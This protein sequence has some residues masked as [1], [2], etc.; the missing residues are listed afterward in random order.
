MNDGSLARA[1]SLLFCIVAHLTVILT[2]KLLSLP[3][4][5]RGQLKHEQ[6]EHWPTYLP[7]SG[8]EVT[9]LERC[10]MLMLLLKSL[11]MVHSLTFAIYFIL[12][13]QT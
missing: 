12:V 9:L 1:V 4:T 3:Y 6:G 8:L 13:F 5:T 11:E 10:L 7:C 2:F